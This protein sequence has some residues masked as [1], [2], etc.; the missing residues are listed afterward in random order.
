MARKK[1]NDEPGVNMDSLMDALTNVVAVLI[2][3]LI[4]LQVD[5][6]QTVEK[7]LGELKPASA[8]QIEQAKQQLAQ[9]NLQLDKQKSMLN[10]PAPKPED[11]NKVEADLALLDISL[12]DSN[13]KLLEI[14]KVKQLLATNQK[15]ADEEKSK[16]DLI[17][18]E[19]SRIKALLDQTPIPKA[20]QPTVVK[21]PNSRDIPT[22]ANIYYCYIIKDQAHLVDPITAKKMVMD[23]FNRNERLLFREFIKI[24]GKPD[25]RVYDQDKV[26]KFYEQ[27]NLMVRSQSVS[28][29]YNRPWTKLTMRITLDPAKGDA[30]LADMEQP[31]GRF[32][33]ICYK[34]KSYYDCVLIFKVN[35]NGFATYLKARE[36]ADSLNIP[37]GWE[38]DGGTTLSLPLDFQVNR[39][40]NPPEAKPAPAKPAV[41]APK[42]KLD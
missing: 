22:K 16:T 10:A 2:L 41:P 17:L 34:V 38:I 39:L 21:I 13:V 4:L 11:L 27:K 28:V 31:K 7:L 30:S 3:I 23:E 20:P 1:S 36:I 8:E 29:P 37:C 25:T 9:V 14:N 40:E 32:Y 33:N 12:K 42:R 6:G 19:I 26:V 15:L 5:V 18:S 35:P 24:K